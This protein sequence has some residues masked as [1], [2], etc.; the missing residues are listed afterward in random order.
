MGAIK[1]VNIKLISAFNKQNI[2]NLIG[3]FGAIHVRTMYASF[4]ASGFAGVRGE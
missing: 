3:N 2:K 4:Q 1:D